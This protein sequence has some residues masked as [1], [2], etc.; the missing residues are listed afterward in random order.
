MLA[1]NVPRPVLSVLVGNEISGNEISGKYAFGGV[2]RV[3]RL[4]RDHDRHLSLLRC[5]VR[6]HA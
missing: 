3:T 2:A 5:V 4:G 1:F 6:N